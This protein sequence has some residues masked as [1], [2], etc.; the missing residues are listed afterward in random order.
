MPLREYESR[1]K[2][3]KQSYEREFEVEPFLL[4][5][6]IQNRV[7]SLL[8]EKSD[9]EQLDELTTPI[10]ESYIQQQEDN[11]QT[12][13][14]QKLVMATGQVQVNYQQEDDQ[15]VLVTTER[16][17]DNKK[18]PLRNEQKQVIREQAGNKLVQSMTAYAHNWQD[19]AV[20]ITNPAHKGGKKAVDVIKHMA[21]NEELVGNLREVLPFLEHKKIECERDAWKELRNPIKE[22]KKHQKSEDNANGN[23]LQ[24]IVEQNITN[25]NITIEQMK[26]KERELSKKLEQGIRTMRTEKLEP[27]R[28]DFFDLL[29]NARKRRKEE[30]EE[31]P[32]AQN[33]TIIDGQE[34]KENLVD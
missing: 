25:K 29:L 3:Y 26:A 33:D 23:Q 34:D 4:Q 27:T 14:L 31:I 20:E 13:I 6:T 21:K 8:I 32:E 7:Q 24:N 28:D 11:G 19:G 12:E 16:R 15:M 22:L 1:Q 2:L 10:K 17:E 9:E 18:E 30:E 5:K